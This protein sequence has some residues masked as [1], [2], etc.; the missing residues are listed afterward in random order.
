M[1]TLVAF[2][3]TA[4]ELT[5]AA[6]N[7][8]PVLPPSD[9]PPSRGPGVNVTSELEGLSEAE[10]LAIQVQIDAGE[11]EI[12]W[13]GYPNY[14]IAPAEVSNP[15]TGAA[16][17]SI[18]TASGEVSVSSAAAPLPGQVLTATSP[19]NA[20]WKET[21]QSEDLK[22]NELGTEFSQN[23]TERA[24]SMIQ[25]LSTEMNEVTNEIGNLNE[26]LNQIEARFQSQINQLKEELFL[27]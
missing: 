20:V 16:A 27:K 23:E 12:E 9:S 11:I 1:A 5:M 8:P 10:Y 6:G 19:T 2:N 26:R 24:L 18:E 22:D 21:P 25:T 17:A 3:L 13:D 7:E 15:Y 14:S 4:A